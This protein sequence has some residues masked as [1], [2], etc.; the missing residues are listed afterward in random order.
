MS[1][2]DVLRDAD[3]AMYRAKELGRDRFEFFDDSMRAAAVER[4]Q[5]DAELRRALERGEFELHYQPLL[6][7]GTGAL[8]GLESLIRW[9]HPVR[10]MVPPNEFIPAA[11]ASGLIRAIGW[12]VLQE[13]LDQ[14]GR[15]RETASPME[16]TTVGVNVSPAQLHQPDFVGRVG[17]M[18]DRS[19]TPADQ[20]CIELTESALIDDD[21]SSLGTVQALKDLGVRIALD[22]FG[23][24]Y[25]SL[26]Y[27]RRF[28]VDTLKIDISFVSGIGKDPEDDVIVATIIAMAQQLGHQDRCRG[29]RDERAAGHAPRVGVHDRP[30]L[31]DREAYACREPRGRVRG[32]QRQAGQRRSRTLRTRSTQ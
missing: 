23:T 15:W 3:A 10:G 5:L 17:A 13:A 28:P 27:L 31:S 4:L 29:R 12:W 7:I 32:V 14:A 19:G 30:G 6:N 1:P 26:T 20:I 21:A 22:D 2:E 24:G 11:E 25:S 9:N 18:I 16:G 8:V